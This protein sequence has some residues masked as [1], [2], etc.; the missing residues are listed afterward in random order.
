MRLTTIFP[1]RFRRSWYRNAVYAVSFWCATASLCTANTDYDAALALVRRAVESH[2]GD[3]ARFDTCAGTGTMA[4]IHADLERRWE[5]DMSFQLANSKMWMSLASTLDESD[6]VIR[7]DEMELVADGTTIAAV[8]HWP[9]FNPAGCE[10]FI[11]PDDRKG[12]A[13]AVSHGKVDLRA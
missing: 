3:W 8:L 11:H 12:L 1:P 13:A 2:A 10:V 7:F 9:R 4:W 6:L 5:C